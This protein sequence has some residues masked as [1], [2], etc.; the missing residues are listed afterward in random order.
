MNRA[1]PF[2][3]I[4]R[5]TA[6]EASVVD[7]SPL[8]PSHVEP[9]DVDAPD[10]DPPEL[11]A[12]PGESSQVHSARV[13]QSARN[14]VVVAVGYAASVRF[15]EAL[16]S[17]PA[18]P[19][20]ICIP[21]AFI[22]TALLLTPP[23]QW[24][25]VLVSTLV[26]QWIASVGQDASAAVVFTAFAIDAVC[27]TLA[28]TL[29]RRHVDLST[30]LRGPGAIGAFTVVSLIAPIIGLL[31]LAAMFGIRVPPH[32]IT[33]N[34]PG[35]A[36]MVGTSWIVAVL[37][38]ALA[39]VTLV[40][41]VLAGRAAVHRALAEP[42]IVIPWG[43]VIEATALTAAV[44]V[45]SAIAFSGFAPDSVART[46]AV[47]APLPV[48]LWAT[49]RFGLVGAASALLIGVSVAMRGLVHGIGFL[50]GLPTASDVA[51]HQALVFVFSTLLL[52]F[53]AVLDER[54]HTY[55]QLGESDER[56][57]FVT[58]AGAVFAYILDRSSDGVTTDPPLADLLGVSTTERQS[59]V[60]WWSR[61][62]PD[63]R[64]SLRRAWA[65]RRANTR[66][67]REL[68]RIDFRVLD[69]EGN[70]HWF[71]D[72]PDVHAITE[73]GRPS[74]TG[75]VADVTELKNAE[76]DAAER[77]RELAHV[78][79]T[80]II[81]EL[82]AALA[83]EIRQPLTA[84]LINSQTAVRVLD[85]QPP[86]TGAA[87]EILHQLAADGRRAGEVI[88]RVRAF[89]RKDDL[90]RGPIDLNAMLR[91]AVQLVRHDT[92]RRRVEIRFALAHEAMIVVGDRVQLQQV[93]LN[94]VLNALEA[95]A[96]RPPQ[97]ER[98]VLIET[99][100]AAHHTA[101]VTIRDTGPG[102]ALERQA[103]IFEPFVTSKSNGLGVGL[104]ITRTIVE[105]HGGII[106]CESDPSVGGAT[107]IV[108]LPLVSHG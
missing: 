40:P 16:L 30:N 59:P 48:A 86:D 8:E 106:W 68:A 49:F 22:L 101:T 6:A 17:T 44:A 54:R 41:T 9:P 36:P 73:S 42:R 83:H 13:R 10:G 7:S 37:A 78:A 72:T 82:A 87:R 1:P 89:A 100:R 24:W 105:A 35:A 71:R 77:S 31:G 34:T 107:F 75:A 52:L 19:P 65:E 95:L 23:G 102:V 61:V 11:D 28:A 15:T 32:V 4:F 99:A 67:G 63:D 81:G 58:R 39:Y 64:P 91:D 84:I 76:R 70:V 108:A 21:S 92:I 60:W 20:F 50:P 25:V 12:A 69:D 66:P 51:V 57:A 56:Y 5:S 74:I 55:G 88:Q 38:S 45:V 62:H 14:A 93:V 27:S 46:I 104:S 80:S 26:G 2:P 96:E 90:E 3:T 33:A 85:S 94:L 18:L 47:L 29:I 43:S 98:L 79:R 103:A 53:A 97:S